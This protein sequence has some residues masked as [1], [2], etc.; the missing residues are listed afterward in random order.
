MI[1][2]S[3]W[4]KLLGC[5]CCKKRQQ[6]YVQTGSD[7]ADLLNRG[8][9]IVTMMKMIVFMTPVMM[10]INIKK[11][12]PISMLTL[13]RGTSC[14]FKFVC[15]LY[16]YVLVHTPEIILFSARMMLTLSRG[17]SPMVTMMTMRMFMTHVILI[18]MLT[19]SRGASPM[20]TQ[21]A[22]S[23]KQRSIRVGWILYFIKV[24]WTLYFIK[25]GW[26]LYFIKVGWILYF[27]KVGLFCFSSRLNEIQIWLELAEFCISLSL[28][29]FCIS[30]RLAEFCTSSKLLN[31]VFLQSWSNFVGHQDGWILFSF[32]VSWILHSDFVYI[33]K[34][35]SWI[36]SYFVFDQI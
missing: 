29:G 25:V 4:W 24:G 11:I 19:L 27:I 30:L 7:S 22:R 12:L 28:A 34:K 1:L 36:H 33:C 2:K 5:G 17:A 13:S 26:I 3:W 21:P 9:P 15:F 16:V 23:G 18:S 10:I 32:K 6:I 35:V 20:V 14:S 31:F 8:K